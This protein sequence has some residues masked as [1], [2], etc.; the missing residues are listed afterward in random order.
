MAAIR[1]HLHQDV[2]HVVS[3]AEKVADWG[4]YVGKYPWVALGV[5]CGVGYFLVPKR[6]KVEV[7]PVDVSSLPEAIA[8]GPA[9]VTVVSTKEAV[10]EKEKSGLL[11]A[12]FGLLAPLAV[13]AAQG[14]A[15]KYL[16]NWIAQHQ[17][18]QSGPPVHPGAPS[19]EA[20]PRTFN[21]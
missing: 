10:R 8:S 13:R 20:R 18:L 15:L 5:A 17:L 7:L 14:Y 3:T 11:G 2:R 9:S 16:E 1:H 19:S 21:P 12:A 4:R 6:K